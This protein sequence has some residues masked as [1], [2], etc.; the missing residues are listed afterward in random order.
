MRRRKILGAAAWIA[1]APSAA[2]AQQPDGLRHIGVLL[3]LAED[4]AH[5]QARLVA[6]RQGLQ[7]RGW[8]EGRNIRI[9]YR[10][11]PGGAQVQ[12][13]ARELVATRPDVILAHTINVAA[14]LQQ[15]TRA[16]PIVFVSVGDPIG[17]G[18]IASLAR[19]GGNLT[20][21]MTFE[22]SVAGKWIAML[23]EVAPSMRRAAF[24]ANPTIASYG[25]YLRA[26]EAAAASLGIELLPYPVQIVDQI[27]PAIERFAQTLDGGLIVPPDVFTVANSDLIIALAERHRLPAIYAFSNLTQAGGLMSYGTDRIEEMRQAS[28]Y[29][30]R[31]LRGDKPSDLPV[32]APTKFEIVINL[33]TAKS[34]GVTIPPVL[35]L[36]ADELIE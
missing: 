4:D 24:V 22:A 14:A 27:V 36:A 12:A 31:I 26:T 30:D 1:G 9:E 5:I 17:A 29:V 10:F 3:G 23:K 2:S 13:R 34:I 6:L 21:L 20:G 11:A 7:K 16:I 18:F 25:Y 19:P 15:E 33:R 32:Q 28:A 8:V 35:L